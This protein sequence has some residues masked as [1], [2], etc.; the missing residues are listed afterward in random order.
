MREWAKGREQ[1][2]TSLLS[3]PFTAQRDEMVSVMSSAPPIHPPCHSHHCS[4]TESRAAV[5]SC[6]RLGYTRAAT[7]SAVGHVV[8][9]GQMEWLIHYRRCLVSSIPEEHMVCECQMW[10]WVIVYQRMRWSLRRIPVTLIVSIGISRPFPRVKKR[11]REEEVANG[12]RRSLRRERNKGG[13]SITGP[14]IMQRCPE[15]YCRLHKWRAIELPL[16]MIYWP[17]RRH[18]L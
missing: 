14:E 3:R 6:P 15:I 17:R 16:F 2:L 8:D 13:E 4:S 10:E 9:E 11:E 5:C 12:L 1:L 18:G 7:Q